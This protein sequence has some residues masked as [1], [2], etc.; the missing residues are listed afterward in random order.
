MRDLAP[1]PAGEIRALTVLDA[2][3]AGC[4]AMAVLDNRNAPHLR[5]GEVAVVDIVDCDLAH[6]ELYAVQFGSG[7]S[8]TQA[9]W[10]RH[11][12]QGHWWTYTLNRP[13]DWP[14]TEAWM[15]GGKTVPSAD[16]P[17]RPGGLEEK[18]LGRVIGLLQ[19]ATAQVSHGR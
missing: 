5:P 13:R 6:G 18:I 15:R 9:L 7:P 4:R 8:I 16:G 11:G 2:V 19:P 10:R 1:T 17:Y 12:D 3:P 14:E